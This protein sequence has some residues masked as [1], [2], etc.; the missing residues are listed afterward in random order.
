MSNHSMS[1]HLT[2]N[3]LL[4]TIRSF[5]IERFDIEQQGVTAK[6]RADDMDAVT[7]FELEAQRRRETV[8]S[9]RDGA[10]AQARAS[11]E[12][13]GARILEPGRSRRALG[14]QSE[15]EPTPLARQ[16]AG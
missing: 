10:W 16:A 3:Y 2:S 13:V 4:D 1:N 8:A 14:A 6:G 7:G 5:E 12:T 9:D 15:C 11:T